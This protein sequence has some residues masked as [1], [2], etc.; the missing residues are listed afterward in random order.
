MEKLEQ[1]KTFEDACA[2]LGLDPEQVI[3]DFSRYPERDRNA[4]V[5]HA[6]L[7]IITRAAN[8]LTN[9]GEEWEPNWNNLKWDKYFPWFEM[10]GSSGFRFNGYDG[11]GSYSSVGSRLCF[12]TRHTA[13]Y[14]GKQF[15]D[16]YRDYFVI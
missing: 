8:K 6:K 15:V 14:V 16:L 4:M 5:A 10:G 1:L 12:I 7:V 13:E 3:P 9:S 2:V 11:W